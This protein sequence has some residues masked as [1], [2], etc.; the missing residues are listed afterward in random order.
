M[1]SA[2]KR[3]FEAACQLAR[4]RGFDGKTLIHPAQIKPANTIFSPDDNEIAQAQ[5]HHRSLRLASKMLTRASI[6]LNGNMVERLHLDQA[7]A[8]VD[9]VKQS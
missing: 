3:G 6:S 9:R 4:A 8:L 5:T 2:M 1:I 7:L